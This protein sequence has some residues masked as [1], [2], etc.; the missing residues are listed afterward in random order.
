[1]GAGDEA[2][3]DAL[4]GR[5]QFSGDIPKN[6]VLRELLFGRAGTYIIH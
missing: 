4:R 5:K 2:G 1:M 6:S 3:T